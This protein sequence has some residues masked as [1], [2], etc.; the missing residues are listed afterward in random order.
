MRN[1]T[2]VQKETDRRLQEGC[3]L[4]RS[5]CV[6]LE[7]VYSEGMYQSTRRNIVENL[8]L[9]QTHSVSLRD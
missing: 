9:Q 3:I 7:G 2:Q 4:K 8:N 6:E 1:Y 5:V